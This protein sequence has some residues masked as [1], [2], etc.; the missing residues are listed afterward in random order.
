MKFIDSKVPVKQQQSVKER[1]HN[2]AKMSDE[3]EINDQMRAE[4]SGEGQVKKAEKLNE[5]ERNRTE[6]SKLNDEEV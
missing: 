6:G 5:K 4:Y 3:K 1:E 2:C